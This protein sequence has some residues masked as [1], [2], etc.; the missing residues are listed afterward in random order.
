MAATLQQLEVNGVQIPVIYE[1]SSPFQP[2]TSHLF[3]VRAAHL[4]LPQKAST[5]GLHRALQA[6]CLKKAQKNSVV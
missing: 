3:F 5:M 4:G 6:H 1:D 2:L